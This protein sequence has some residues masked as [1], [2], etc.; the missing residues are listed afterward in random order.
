MFI[1]KESKRR[2]G[3]GRGGATPPSCGGTPCVTTSVVKECSLDPIDGPIFKPSIRYTSEFPTGAMSI[4][5]V[6]QRMR[7]HD[8]IA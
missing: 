8:R 6:Q 7:G 1:H 5:T 2:E 3:G 4:L